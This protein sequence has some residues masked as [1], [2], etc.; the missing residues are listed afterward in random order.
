MTLQI[1]RPHLTLSKAPRCPAQCRVQKGVDEH[2]LSWVMIPWALFPLPSVS[3]LQTP[4]WILE[5]CVL[6]SEGPLSPS[7]IT[8]LLPGVCLAACCRQDIPHQVSSRCFW[9]DLGHDGNI[10]TTVVLPR[11]PTSAHPRTVTPSPPRKRQQISGPWRGPGPLAGQ[12][13]QG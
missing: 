1:Q 5:R 2:L 6:D 4:E 12:A 8:M 3:S 13:P 7:R 10:E 9:L 11:G